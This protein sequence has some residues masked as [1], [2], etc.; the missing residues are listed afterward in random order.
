MRIIALSNH[1]GGC[2]KTTTSINLSACLAHLGK[3]VLLIDLDPQGHSGCGLNLERDGSVFGVSALFQKVHPDGTTL[4]D[5][6]QTAEN[7]LDVMVGGEELNEVEE[8]LSASQK[9]ETL[10]K[11]NLQKLIGETTPYDYIILDC[12]PNLGVLTRN[13][14]N[15]A[16]EVIIPVEPSYFSLH[17]LAKI[18]ETMTKINL[19]RRKDLQ[20]HALITL[21]NASTQFAREVY[22]DVKKNFGN[23]LFS[24][25]I[26]ECIELKE[27][28]SAGES[29]VTYAP[30]SIA[31]QEYQ[32]LAKEFL[33]RDWTRSLPRPKEEKKKTAP[34]S[35]KGPLEVPG[36]VLFQCDIK[37]ASKVEIA[38]DFNDWKPQPMIRT[39]PGDHWFRVISV[40]KGEYRYKFVVDG[41]WIADPAQLAERSNEFGTMDSLI[42]IG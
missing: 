20:V 33:E 8:R 37:N 2:G 24:T 23:K 6:K 32:S 3:K 7:N 17:G 41:E 4:Q 16:D 5:F 15:A 19:G 39:F 29:I 25:I 1:K 11:A 34:Q 14:L 35:Q 10:L 38:G 12:P 31:F 40:A 28:A 13:A 27:A 30:L 18:S 36:G 42:T 21:F 9:K 26:H 22:E